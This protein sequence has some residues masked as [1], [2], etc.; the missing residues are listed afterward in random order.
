MPKWPFLASFSGPPGPFAHL[1]DSIS[2]AS[3][4]AGGQDGVWY[5]PSVS[6]CFTDVAGTTPAA[7]TDSVALIT[8]IS[9]NGVDA[10]QA[11]AAS[12]PTFQTTPDRI[13][14][15]GVG[16]VLGAT[17]PAINGTMVLAT[18]EGTQAYGVDISAGA[19]EVGAQGGLYF[20]GTALV[21]QIIRDGA[22]TSREI[23]YTVAYMQ[24]RGGGSDYGTVTSLSSYWQDWNF[25]T[26]FPLIDTSSVTNLTQAWRGCTSLTSFP[27]IDTALATSMAFAWRS[28]TGLTSFP[29]IDTSSATSMA[30]TWQTCSSLTTIPASV[31]TTSCTNM[32]NCLI[33]TNLTQTAIDDILVAL[34]ANGTSS[35]TFGQSG[36]NAPSATGEDSITTLRGRGWT[37][38]VTGGF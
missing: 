22:M 17:L 33:N 23:A 13:V 16:D 38:T 20:P 25:L 36:G 18:P 7:A 29:L 27:L 12:R 10:T 3:L 2:I 34:E 15:D 8:D 19:F 35:G 4:F 14:F 1:R 21:G 6:T 37:I 24:D 30:F 9:P 32:S 26:S 11:T 5:E 28:C 31:F